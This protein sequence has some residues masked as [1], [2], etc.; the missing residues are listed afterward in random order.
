ML[1][2]AIL[3]GLSFDPFSLFD[4]GWRPAEIGTGGCDVVQV[5]MV[6]QAIEVP[7]GDPDL[8]LEITGHGREIYQARPMILT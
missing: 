5:L 8:G 1:Q 2:A 7:D 3:D 4:G 6:T